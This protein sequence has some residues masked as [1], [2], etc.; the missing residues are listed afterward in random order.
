MKNIIYLLLSLLL[1]FSLS[2]QLTS[3]TNENSIKD[4]EV[5]FDKNLLLGSWHYAGSYDSEEE[6]R[7]EIEFIELLSMGTEWIAINYIVFTED[8]MSQYYWFDGI[9]VQ[10]NSSLSYQ[11][12]LTSDEIVFS[13]ESTNLGRLKIEHIENIDEHLILIDENN[14]QYYLFNKS[15]NLSYLLENGVDSSEQNYLDFLVF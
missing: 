11:Y 7:N 1:C 14:Q 8:E 4:D 13:T 6:I 9:G 12:Q 10:F 3:E 2:C 15:G 5:T